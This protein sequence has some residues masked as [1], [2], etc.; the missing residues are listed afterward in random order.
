MSSIIDDLKN[1]K[2]AERDEIA[3]L[4]VYQMNGITYSI[5]IN[6]SPEFRMYIA[7]AIDAYVFGADINDVLLCKDID[8]Y[9]DEI[10]LNNDLMIN[11]SIARALDI[12][13]NM[14]NDLYDSLK[15][16]KKE[17]SLGEVQYFASMARLRESFKAVI[18]LC[19]RSL[20]IEMMPILRLIYEQL[21]WCCYVIDE[22]DE[23]K[24][25]SNW[26]T[27]NT[28]YL[29]EKISE[30]YGKLYSTLSSEAHMAPNQT[31]KFIES[32]TDD[33]IL[34]NARSSKKAKRDIPWIIQ[35]YHI[36]IQVFQ[37]G[38]KHFN[39]KKDYYQEYIDAQIE[40]VK[41]WLS[42]HG[43]SKL[44]ATFQDSERI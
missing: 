32:I 15:A 13:T 12:A 35:L 14:I 1:G 33:G 16:I 20:F 39:F 38:I 10:W 5:P 43:D 29:K 30:S 2:F 41:H 37:Y 4:Q 42:I 21:C 34:F 22:L 40:I 25:K 24:I 27:K 28:K 19:D 7:S 44:K 6:S 17:F 18:I 23:E 36:Y 11:F 3:D 26:T 31:G 9:T 8:N